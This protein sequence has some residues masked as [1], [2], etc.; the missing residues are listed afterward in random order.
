MA[1]TQR[2]GTFAFLFALDTWILT[3]LTNRTHCAYTCFKLLPF[4]LLPARSWTRHGFKHAAGSS[5][6]VCS[7]LPLIAWTYFEYP[8]TPNCCA[9]YRVTHA[10]WFLFRISIIDDLILPSAFF[11]GHEVSPLVWWPTLNYI[12]ILSSY[13][14]VNTLRLGYRIA[15]GVLLGAVQRF[16]KAFFNLNM[17]CGVPAHRTCSCIYACMHHFDETHKHSA[18]SNLRANFLYR[19]SDSRRATFRRTSL[20]V[21]VNKYGCHTVDFRDAESHW[22]DFCRHFLCQ[23]L[24]KSEKNCVK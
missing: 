12:Q 6:V 5:L 17:S 19:M 8:N 14:S 16:T 3:W 11:F 1:L 2:C 10:S 21:R 4:S 13:R 18:A 24:P 23:I 20:S 9:K 7:T 22:L 15:N